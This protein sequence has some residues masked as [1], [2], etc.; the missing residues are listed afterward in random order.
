MREHRD[1][2]YA[3]RHVFPAF[4]R[5]HVRG[6]LT[7]SFV[8]GVSRNHAK[9]WLENVHV[10]PSVC[11]DSAKVGAGVTDVGPISARCV[12]WAAI[13]QT[14]RQ[15]LTFRPVLAKV[16][17]CRPKPGRLRPMFARDLKNVVQ[18]RAKLT[19]VARSWAG[20]DRPTSAKFGPI[21]PRFG[22]NRPSFFTFERIHPE[23]GRTPGQH[24]RAESWISPSSCRRKCV[25]LCPAHCSH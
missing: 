9:A 11:P 6:A 16:G 3:R 20:F 23:T 24:R 4:R 1:R 2:T 12:C 17:R 21:R 22:R 15:R 7:G 18:C 10:P 14:F 5:A 8:K 13:G 19:D 25:E